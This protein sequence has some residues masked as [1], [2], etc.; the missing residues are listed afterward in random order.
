MK[1]E[2]VD[3]QGTEF[4]EETA[5]FLNWMKEDGAEYPKLEMRQ[6]NPIYRGVHAA[7]NIRKGET[8]LYVPHQQIMT[9]DM[10]I[11]SPIGQLME[12]KNLRGRLLSPKHSF[13]SALVMQE[14][15]KEDTYYKRY[16]EI[17]PQQFDNFPIFYTEDEKAWLKGS[18]FIEQI[19]SKIIDIHTDYN[20]ICLEVPEF[21]QFPIEEYS[22]V[23]MM[24]CSRVFGFNIEGEKAE[25]LVPYADML[26]HKMPRQTSWNYSN[27]LKGFI[28][29]ADAGIKKGDQVY[30]SY[31]NKCNNR[32]LLNY[33]FVNL[34]NEADN[35]VAL[36]VTL[37]ADDKLTEQK[38]LICKEQSSRM[39]KVM[40]NLDVLQMTKFLSFVRFI[41]F[42]ESE[43]QLNK[44]MYS[45]NH[46]R[47]VEEIP[48]INRRNET[49]VFEK[50]KSLCQIAL[51]EYPDTHEEDLKLLAEDEPPISK[52]TFNQR[53]MVLYRSGEKSIL[54]YLISMSNFCLALLTM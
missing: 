43:E 36:T 40:A 20:L 14:R 27:T 42:D 16:L 37:A 18:P 13:L 49:L 9:L 48:I 33:G 44:Y 11:K 1:S 54:H 35:E 8:I 34:N 39:F 41:V 12:A 52:L 7:E 5:G 29:V 28:I 50:I 31:G 21:A 47:S 6:Y 30:D 2:A 26:N 32:F 3:M 51:A 24:I 17:L 46:T 15:R 10:A 19:D 38:R 25:G 45:W 22:Q 23:R 4:T 53:N